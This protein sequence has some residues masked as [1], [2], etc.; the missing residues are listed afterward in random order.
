MELNKKI[1]KHVALMS[2]SLINL[3]LLSFSTNP[4]HAEEAKQSPVA[5]HYQ[6][7]T[8]D[9]IPSSEKSIILENISNDSPE[10]QTVNQNETF[11]LIYK[12]NPKKIFGFLPATGSTESTLLTLT[13]VAF[14][15]LGISFVKKSKKITSILLVTVSGTTLALQSVQALESR[16]LADY[17]QTYQL[18]LGEQLP[19]IRQI[20]NY[21]YLGYLT[22]SDYDQLT[23]HLTPS[24]QTPIEESAPS[25]S[26]E[27]KEEVK[28]LTIPAGL[29]IAFSNLEKIL[30]YIEKNEILE[31]LSK[32]DL[33]SKLA[34]T[35]IISLV[36]MNDFAILSDLSTNAQIANQLLVHYEDGSLDYLP[37]QF[38]ETK[39][40]ILYY[41]LS[42][43]GLTYTPT[44]KIANYSTILNQVLP[45][46]QAVEFRSSSIYQTL[47]LTENVE[48]AMDKLYLESSFNKV[49][50][51]LEDYL[52]KALINDQSVHLDDE[53]SVNETIQTIL[54]N[55]EKILLS[56]AYLDRWYDIQFGQVNSKELTMFHTDFFG[57]KAEALTALIEFGKNGYNSYSP[58]RNF[59][60]YAENLSSFTDHASLPEFLEAYRQA[61]LPDYSNNDWFKES[62]DAY[63]VESHSLVLSP[64]QNQQLNLYERLTNPQIPEE[65]ITT[66][67]REGYRNML[68]PL[69][70]TSDEHLYIVS[71]LSN[72]IFSSYDRYLD[73]SLKETNPEEYQAALTTVK[74]QILAD[75]ELYRAHYDMWYRILPDYHRHT[76]LYFQPVWGGHG[77]HKYVHGSGWVGHWY[78]ETGK[79][80]P[81]FQEKMQS[82]ASEQTTLA[83]QEVFGPSG[84]YFLP[85]LTWAGAYAWRQEVNFVITPLL[86]TDGAVTLTHEMVHAFDYDKY[87]LGYNRRTGMQL[88]AYPEGMLQAPDRVDYPIV[89]FNSLFDHSG[90]QGTRYHNSSPERFQSTEDLETYMHGLF[91]LIYTL[92]YAEGN[93]ILKQ[94]KEIQRQW[95][96]KL[97]TKEKAIPGA[98]EY[99]PY[100]VNIKR[101]FT[102]EEWSTMELQSIDDLI[103][104]DVTVRRESSNRIERDT[105]NPEEVMNNGY[106]KLSLFA[107]IWATA[108]TERVPGDLSFRRTA[109]ELLADIGYVDG[110][111]PYMSNQYKQADSD[112]VPDSLIFA[113]ILP[114]YNGDY[115]SFKKAMYQERIQ[116][117]AL[118]KPV[119]INYDGQ[120]LTITN[121]EQLQT[122]MDQAVQSDIAAGHF[123]TEDT[124]VSELK[125]VLHDAY[126]K[127]T[128]DYRTSIFTE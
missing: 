15:I 66:R 37:I 49:K 2:T 42:N 19:S 6:Y 17:N 85:E 111:V 121:F 89:G 94:D 69:L 57:G 50:S 103:D 106:H 74:E 128:D 113:N 90:H 4:I 10:K 55:K 118:L 81:E 105:E 36:P 112:V 56:L 14:L 58:Q 125:G 119:T 40:N 107:P 30:P 54:A 102:D 124:K 117:L 86:G 39:D 62:I 24:N 3:L 95:F 68:L 41:Q 51:Q 25:S 9:E 67:I 127:L 108:T 60:S 65:V 84:T 34:S 104:F 114:E 98:E 92:E 123:T 80:T 110:M 63:V 97:E 78:S 91:D 12:T 83:I 7:I 109:F 46:L 52:K 20:K 44:Q 115:K 77:T 82:E 73:T 70:T 8:Q 1:L 18:T 116:K 96:H 101:D 64:E 38:L 33:N 27:K 93:A 5:I 11:Y 16:T 29:E 99:G 76:L 28:E 32:I 72:L 61:F 48:N 53:S 100:G 45:T 59:Q 13:G 43:T 122:L 47:G 23:K 22:K 79:I 26:V 87:L 21:S 75:A 35:N 71:N 120:E 88:E 31:N 126:L